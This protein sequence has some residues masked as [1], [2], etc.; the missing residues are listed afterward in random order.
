[1]P[2]GEYLVQISNHL[3]DASLPINRMRMAYTEMVLILRQ[4]YQ[5]CRLVHGDLSEYNILF[6][7]VG[8]ADKTALCIEMSACKCIFGH[9]EVDFL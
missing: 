7:Q 8:H 5:D 1:M 4:L 9:S 3:Q 6:H 2:D